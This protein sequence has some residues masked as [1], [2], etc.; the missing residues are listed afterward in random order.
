MQ[1]R[2]PVAGSLINSLLSVMV[3]AILSIF[4]DAQNAIKPA[5]PPGHG[6]S[7][8]TYIPQRV[9]DAREKRYGDFES[10]LYDLASHEVVFIGEQHDDPATHRLER[11]ILEG[12]ARRRSSIIVSLEMFERDTQP[13]IDDYLAGRLN[14]EGFL[15]V[16]RPW[17][18]YQ[19]DY[20]PLV[21]FAK[22][23]HWPVLGANIPRK[24]ASLVSREGLAAIER[25][26]PAERSLVAQ[27]FQCPFDDYFKRFAEVMSSHPGADPESDKDKKRK[28]DE[29]DV[30]QR[31]MTERFYFAQCVKDETMAESISR[32]VQSTGAGIEKPLIVHYNGSFHSDFRL[33]TA[34]RVRARLPKARTKVVSIVP[35]KSLDLIDHDQYKKR[36]DY[37]LF[38]LSKQ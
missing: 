15:K 30:K 23:H 35:L 5:V 4:V 1:K 3:L 22:A 25:L 36:G 14:E 32:R 34:A 19:T 18:R 8:S 27:S 12:L 7:S 16:S 31:Q 37:I 10:M 21:E 29:V 33:G 13:A 11:A 24:Y 2:S 38:T 6:A 17:P 20:R 26:S 28:K 9:Y